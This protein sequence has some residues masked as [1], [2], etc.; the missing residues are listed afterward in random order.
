MTNVLCL[1]LHLF[2]QA[3][4]NLHASCWFRY[5]VMYKTN[6][7]F[8]T[9]HWRKKTWGQAMNYMKS[10]QSQRGHFGFVISHSGTSCALYFCLYYLLD[11]YDFITK[12]AQWYII[13]SHLVLLPFC[14]HYIHANK[15]WQTT[16][17]N[18]YF[19]QR[20]ISYE[21]QSRYSLL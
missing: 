12:E 18:V 19:Q 15:E 1:L 17:I 7:L 16:F 13:Y 8:F 4:H 14:Q 6:E 2:W 21:S 5:C 3:C 20:C 10:G 9:L 11:K